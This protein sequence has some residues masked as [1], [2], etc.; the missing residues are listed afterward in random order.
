MTRACRVFIPLLAGAGL[1]F[2]AGSA[3]AYPQ[4]QFSSGTSRCSSCHYA[5]AGGGLIRG[6]GRD[7]AGEELSTWEGD[8]SFL[9]GAA[10]LPKSLAIGFDGRFAVLA[11]NV[12]EAHGSTL[13]Y[14]PM[15]ADAYVRLALGTAFSAYGSIGYRGQVRSVNQPVGSGGA[16]PIASRFISREHYLMWQ[17]AA[18]GVY[19]R[20]GRF[21]APFGLRLAEHYSY[22]RRDL[23]FNLLQESYSLSLGYL[24]K[25]YEVHVTAFM[26]DVVRNVGGKEL[27]GA[28]MLERR[29]G[30]S[31]A[32]GVQGKYGQTDDLA[33]FI[34][35]VF[36]KTYLDSTNALIQAEF[37]VVHSTAADAGVSTD[38]FVGYAGV[39]F[40]P[41]RGLWVTPFAERSQTSIAVRDSATDAGGVQINW[42][43]Y[44]HFELMWMGRFQI[45]AGDS[46][47]LTSMF[48]LHYYL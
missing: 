27:G 36:L 29:V 13:S 2:L 28:A 31:S 34:G 42:F 15:Q 32:L 48:F 10:E 26:P 8:G 3:Q 19:A 4:W 6:Y 44:P 17:P 35:G 45:P 22:V 1:L 24:Q 18:Q 40:F 38:G 21:F 30:D 20:A 9:H 7:A 39:S 11:Q 47:A 25:G 14:F 12:G 23:G 46:T 33:R 43:P 37:N 16:V 41:T 5:P